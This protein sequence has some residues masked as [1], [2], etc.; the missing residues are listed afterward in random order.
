MCARE[1]YVLPLR[2][3]VHSDNIHAEETGKCI[4]FQLLNDLVVSLDPQC[5]YNFLWRNLKCKGRCNWLD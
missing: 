2:N 5:L 3:S 1:N 4:H